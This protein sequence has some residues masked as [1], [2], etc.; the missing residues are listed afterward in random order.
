MFPILKVRQTP[1]V[2]VISKWDASFGLNVWPRS[3]RQPKEHPDGKS[4]GIDAD[5]EAIGRTVGRTRACRGRSRRA[6]EAG[7]ALDRG[8]GPR[9]GSRGR[10]GARLL[11]A[12]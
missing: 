11:R 8:R 1:R 7:G 2:A 12:W 10:G 6:G 5:T 9:R 3:N 4:T